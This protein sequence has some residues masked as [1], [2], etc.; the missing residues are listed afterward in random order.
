M[1]RTTNVP[2]HRSKVGGKLPSWV[3]VTFAFVLTPVGTAL[4]IISGYEAWADATKIET[5]GVVID[6]R[7]FQ[8]ER[9]PSKVPGSWR[10]EWLAEFHTADGPSRHWFPV[11][12]YRTAIEAAPVRDVGKTVAVWYPPGAAE[13]ATIVRPEVLRKS[14]WAGWSAIIAAAGFISIYALIWRRSRLGT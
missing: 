6:A 10:K 5:Q 14:L 12:W 1:E 11:G 4:A 13:E 9:R 3:A 7:V 8:P 2:E